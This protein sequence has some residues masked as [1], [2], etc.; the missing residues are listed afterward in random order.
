MI[1]EYTDADLDALLAM[2][3]AQ[4]FEYPFPHL[5]DPLFISKL[6]LCEGAPSNSYV[7]PGGEGKCLAQDNN[8]GKVVM[9]ALARLTCEIYLLADPYAGTPRQRYA[10][11]LELH[12]AGAADL[13][14]RGLADAHAWL[15]P[16]IAR[17]FG[18]RLESFG[19][20]RDNDWTP[21]CLRLR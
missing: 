19:W 17:R 5:R 12:R 7:S 3:C 2:H 15:P 1:R 20:L 10:R 6:V 11:V 18:R 4:G 14:A 8:G 16:R 13:R 21:Y 9:A